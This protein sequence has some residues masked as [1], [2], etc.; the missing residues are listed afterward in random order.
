MKSSRAL[1]EAVESLRSDPDSAARAA[2]ACAFFQERPGAVKVRI[3]TPE[4]ARDGWSSPLTVVE[5]ALE[6]RPFIVDT[7]EELLRAEG[8]DIRL[9]L[10]PILGVERDADGQLRRVATA[11]EGRIGN[12]WYTS[13]S[14]TSRPRPRCAS[15]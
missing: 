13:R 10:H 12:R 3:F 1:Y 5:T 15:V 2:G 6:D 9:L 7:V 8:G 11:A 14:P 4:R